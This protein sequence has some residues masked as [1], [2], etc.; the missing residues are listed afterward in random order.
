MSVEQV[1]QLVALLAVYRDQ[2]VDGIVDERAVAQ[3]QTRG[4]GDGHAHGAKRIGITRNLQ[5]RLDLGVSGQLGVQHPVPIA[6]ED[7][8][9]GET[10]EPVVEE[11]GLVHHR[12]PVFER[13][14][15]AAG[16]GAKRRQRVGGSADPH[17]AVAVARDELVESALFVCITQLGGPSEQFVVIGRHR[18]AASQFRVERAQQRVLAAGGGREV[19][20]AVDHSIFG[21]E[22]ARNCMGA[23]RH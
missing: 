22:H 18:F 4:W 7:D 12:G 3:D 20:G 19:G 16:R 13:L 9:V 6:V 17:H 14:G 23:T 10:D 2:V 5:Q 11:R 21:D 15:G 1:A 8:E